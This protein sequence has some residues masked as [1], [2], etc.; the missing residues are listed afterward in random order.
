MTTDTSEQG[1]ETRIFNLLLRSPAGS[2]ADNHDYDP[3]I[4]P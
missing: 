3:S 4:L 2:Q 1:L